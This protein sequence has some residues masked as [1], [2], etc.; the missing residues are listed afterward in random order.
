MINETAHEI[1]LTGHQ[2][3]EAR[4]VSGSPDTQFATANEFQIPV[5]LRNSPPTRRQLHDLPLEK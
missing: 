2:W 4:F 1:R 3:W 5:P